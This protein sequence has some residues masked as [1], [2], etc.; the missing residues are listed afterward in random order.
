MQLMIF[1]TV[2][3]LGSAMADVVI[4]AM[5]AEA[6]KFERYVPFENSSPFSLALHSLLIEGACYLSVYKA[7]NDVRKKTQ[8]CRHAEIQ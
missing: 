4:D 3:N 8:I 6:V 7:V 2:Q 5:I 1:L